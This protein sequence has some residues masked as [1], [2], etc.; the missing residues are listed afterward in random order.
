MDRT[1]EAVEDVRFVFEPDLER[2]VVIVSTMFTLG[3]KLL[4]LPYIPFWLDFIVFE[5]AIMN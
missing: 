1:L 4:L 5:T 3:H 2:L